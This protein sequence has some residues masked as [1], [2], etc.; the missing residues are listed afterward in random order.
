MF[1]ILCGNPNKNDL[2]LHANYLMPHTSIIMVPAPVHKYHTYMHL[3]YELGY[4]KT[5]LTECTFAFKLKAYTST[6]Y[7]IQYETYGAA[8]Y[9][10][11][12]DELFGFVVSQYQPVIP[13]HTLHLLSQ[14]LKAELAVE[15]QA[16]SPP[17]SQ[18][19]DKPSQLILSRILG[20]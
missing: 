4:S 3:Y 13:L 10:T 20:M 12:K 11:V 18:G 7:H 14:Q 1:T 17:I 5:L 9:T 19:L 15:E 2:S 6:A 8:V 16:A